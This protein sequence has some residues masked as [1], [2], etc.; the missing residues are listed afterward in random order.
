MRKAG[1]TIG[2]AH[3]IDQA[4]ALLSEWKILPEGAE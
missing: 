1:V 2:I 4:L 3:D